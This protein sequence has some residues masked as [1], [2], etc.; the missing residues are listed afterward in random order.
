MVTSEQMELDKDLD[1]SQHAVH[2]F[3]LS[4]RD[5]MPKNFFHNW[6]HVFDVTQVGSIVWFLCY[7]PTFVV[8]VH[9]SLEQEQTGIFPP[10]TIELL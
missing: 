2:R 5:C 6:T 7:S 1:I 4:V 8:P 3:V 10:K 9:W